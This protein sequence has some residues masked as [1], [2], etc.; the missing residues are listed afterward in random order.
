MNEDGVNLGGIELAPGIRVPESVL[1]YS[2]SSA[3]GPGGQN[4]NKRASKCTLKI[5]I[6]S[7]AMP[8]WARTR[9]YEIAGRLL[10]EDGE[11][12]IQADEHRSQG[13]NRDATMERL[14]TLLVQA[15][16]R[17]KIRRKTKPSRGAKER[18]IQ[19]KKARSEI[20]KGRRNQD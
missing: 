20:K 17:P 18:R 10:S 15:M 5:N 9:F 4:V 12:T 1:E 3:S 6:D 14:R 2:Y 16:T 11:L 7:I 13:Q 8:A 19:S